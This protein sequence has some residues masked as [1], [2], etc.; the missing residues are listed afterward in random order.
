MFEIFNILFTNPIT[1]LLVAFYQGLN[2]IGIPYAFGFAIILLTAVVRLVLYPFMS[3]QI[4]SAHKMQKIAPHM[5][6]IKDKH[7]NDNKRQQE[8][9]MKLYKEHGVNPAGGCI[10]LLVQLPIIYSLYHVL[11]TAVN[12]NSVQEIAAINKVL[13]FN[14]LKIN[15]VWNPSFFGLPLGATPSNLF[16]DALL[17][18]LV[19]FV[20]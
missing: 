10:P 1:N 14:F 2:A 6:A 16:S 11:I 18:I 15:S 4:K 7:K 20:T 19:P 8:E 9:I 5:A 13:Y 3:V 17:I 12:A